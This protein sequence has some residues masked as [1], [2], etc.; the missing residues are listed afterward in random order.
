MR[1]GLRGAGGEDESDD[2]ELSVES[3][4]VERCEVGGLWLR[5]ERED[6]TLEASD[7]E[8]GVS[9]RSCIAR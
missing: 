3:V 8:G 5:R 2:D 6:T 1:V 9:V 7:G 4:E